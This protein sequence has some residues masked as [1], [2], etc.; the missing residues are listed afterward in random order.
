MG[1]SFFLIEDDTIYTHSEEKG[2]TKISLNDTSS[3]KKS[4]N[5]LDTCLLVLKDKRSLLKSKL[6]STRKNS[7]TSDKE[8]E[9]PKSKLKPIKEKPKESSES[10]EE[11]PKTRHK[12]K[13]IKEKPKES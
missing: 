3:L 8:E 1:K 6:K 5:N 4:I 10:E 2:L 13:P 7:E 12:S 9:K 11:K